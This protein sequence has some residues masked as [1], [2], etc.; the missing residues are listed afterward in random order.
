MRAMTLFWKKAD[1]IST[2]ARE[3]N[4]KINA[5]DME[6][7]RLNSKLGEEPPQPRIRSTALPHQLAGAP[8]AAPGHRVGEPIFE[9]VDHQHIHA[10]AENETTPG[11]YNE[12]GVRKYDLVAA[13]K[14]LLNHFRGPPA[15][16]PKL[17]N[18]LAAGSIH[19]LRPLRYE[20]RVA[21]N[22]C[23]AA[24]IGLLLL[25]WGI[26]NFLVKR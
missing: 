13:W 3:L 6:I 25:L 16:N 10:P 26:V 17:I 24:G 23:L 20:K 9:E 5:L 15:N 4:A 18:Y 2:R 7:K 19:G 14:R 11:H 8:A 1:P 22:R 12:L 21:R